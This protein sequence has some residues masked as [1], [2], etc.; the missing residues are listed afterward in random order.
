MSQ[1][2]AIDITLFG[3]IELYLT[4]FDANSLDFTFC[5]I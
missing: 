1:L 4:T 5:K 3:H 2:S